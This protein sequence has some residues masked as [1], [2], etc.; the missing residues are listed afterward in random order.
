[1]PLIAFVI[2]AFGVVWAYRNGYDDGYQ[3]GLDD[4]FN[5]AWDQNRK[6]DKT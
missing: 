1:M 2:I 5:R 3:R 4:G 6:D